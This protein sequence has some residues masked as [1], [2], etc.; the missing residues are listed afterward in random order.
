[1][2]R[3]IVERTNRPPGGCFGQSTYKPRVCIFIICIPSPR[4]H[5]TVTPVGLNHTSGV[6]NPG[7]LCENTW[8]SISKGWAH[9]LVKHWRIKL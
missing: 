3:G 1:M 7:D 4:G 2:R 5:A 6:P 9:S 8:P